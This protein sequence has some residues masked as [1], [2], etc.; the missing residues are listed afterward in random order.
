[1]SFEKVLKDKGLYNIFNKFIEKKTLKEVTTDV[2]N[3][4]KQIIENISK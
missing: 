4:Y 3:A 2:I 1:M